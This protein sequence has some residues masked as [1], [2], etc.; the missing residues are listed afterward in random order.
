MIN[1]TYITLP[2]DNGDGAKPFCDAG[3]DEDTW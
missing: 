1:K 3:D 2:T